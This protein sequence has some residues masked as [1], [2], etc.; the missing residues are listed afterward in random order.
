VETAE[1]AGNFDEARADTLGQCDTPAGFWW[2][3][4]VGP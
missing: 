4:D 3:E 1:K 2:T